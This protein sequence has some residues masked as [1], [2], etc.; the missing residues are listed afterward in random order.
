MSLEE[1]VAGKGRLACCGGHQ[2]AG[3]GVAVVKKW[4][5]GKQKAVAALLL[6][7]M[8]R[9][10]DRDVDGWADC[11]AVIGK[12]GGSDVSGKEV[13]PGDK[14]DAT[15]IR[16]D[17]LSRIDQR[18]VGGAIANGDGVLARPDLDPLVRDRAADV[19]HA[20]LDGHQPRGVGKHPDRFETVGIGIVRAGDQAVGEAARAQVS[21]ALRGQLKRQKR[22]Q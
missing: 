14:F 3:V 18:E 6:D 11:V 20:H 4:D 12:F 1:Q 15:F 21:L 13:P 2:F 17:D 16:H 19:S 8:L 7:E 5:V 22:E 10:G 9:L